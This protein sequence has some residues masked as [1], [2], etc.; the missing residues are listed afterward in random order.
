MFTRNWRVAVCLAAVLGVFPGCATQGNGEE[1]SGRLSIAKATYGTAP[2]GGNAD[3]YTITN[4]NGMVAQI[5]NYGGTVTSLLVPDAAGALADVT[6]GYPSLEGYFENK[7]YLGCLVGRFGNRIAK[8]RFTL[9]GKEY[10]LAVNNE[11]NHLHGGIKGFNK[12][13]WD[14]K[15]AYREGAVG[16]KLTYVSVDGEEGYP[17]TLETTV[18][19]WLTNANELEIV[20]EA[21]TDKA[22]PVNLTYHGYF[23]LDGQGEGDI[24]DHVMMINASRYTP[25]D[26]TLIPTGELA[27]VA[28]TPLDFTMPVAIGERINADHEQIKRGNGYDHNYVLN[29]QDGS[30]A[31]AARVLAP[32]SGRVM[33]VYTTQPGVQF[34]SGNFLDGT[35][36]GKEGKVYKQRYGFCLETQ[37]YPDSVNQ[38]GFPSC[39]LEPGKKYYQK[40]VYRFTTR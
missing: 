24:L 28:N 33:E 15:P 40:T 17:G 20:Y 4:A 1:G 21:V 11:S 2:E 7:P 3:L 13:L 31:L 25:V 37:H 8:G 23:N 18:H 10:V 6:L 36:T 12:V 35:I 39:I 19:Y 26:E 16:L 32:G 9:D 34:Y 38:P 5:T 29:S 30:L 22:T 27:P 14:A